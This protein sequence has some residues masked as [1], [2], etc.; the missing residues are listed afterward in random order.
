MNPKMYM[1]V[2][3]LL[4][5]VVFIVVADVPPVN[6]MLIAVAAGFFALLLVKAW[7]QGKK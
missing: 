6:K 7:G 4:F 1:P 2:A 5:C 3:C